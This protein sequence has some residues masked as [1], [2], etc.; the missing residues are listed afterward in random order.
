MDRWGFPLKTAFQ[1]LLQ[2]LQTVANATFE[3][4]I[5]VGKRSEE[6]KQNVKRVVNFFQNKLE[7]ERR[8]A[9]KTSEE[10]KQTIRE[11]NAV[12]LALNRR[13]RTKKSHTLTEDAFLCASPV[14]RQ[15]RAPTLL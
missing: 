3:L 8:N 12:I 15:K 11:Q 4:V 2:R 7:D 13:L 9:K 14:K 1:T 6:E 10:Q 5:L